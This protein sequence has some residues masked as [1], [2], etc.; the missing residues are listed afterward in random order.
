MSSIIVERQ[1]EYNRLASRQ[2]WFSEYDYIVIGSGSAGSVVASRL[3][4]HREN[5]VLLLEA[6]GPETVLSTM[7]S[8]SETLTQTEMDWNYTIVAQNH[9]CFGLKDQIMSWPRGRVLGGTSSIN[10]MVGLTINIL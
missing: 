2:E 7:P 5:S 8:M 1:N 9:S 10:R 3:S 4:L 6:G